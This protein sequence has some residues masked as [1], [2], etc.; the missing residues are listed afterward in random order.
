MS[1]L[2]QQKAEIEKR[3]AKALA[4]R[5]DVHP[6]I[7]EHYRA[8]AIDRQ[9]WKTT[10]PRTSQGGSALLVVDANRTLYAAM[11]AGRSNRHVRPRNWTGRERV[12]LKRWRPSQ[13]QRLSTL[14][15]PCCRFQ[16]RCKSLELFS[17]IFPSAAF[18][19]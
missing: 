16:S 7:A 2:E 15:P 5:P 3:L 4:D 17:Q 1:E 10:R 9:H 14:E 11:A 12:G 8:K 6:N 13:R 19:S 18:S